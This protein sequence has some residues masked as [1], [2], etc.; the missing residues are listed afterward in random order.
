MK[1]LLLLLTLTVCRSASILA[2]DGSFPE[3]V[4]VT[5]IWDQPPHS[6]FTD[7]VLFNNAFYC[8]FREGFSHVDTTNSGKVRVLKSKDGKDWT[9]VA[10]LAIP[11]ID[12]RD[13]KLTI[14]PDKKLMVTMAGA[15]FAS[16]NNKNKVQRIAPMVSFSDLKGANFSEPQKS[17]LDPAI[18]PSL[19]WI[20]RTTWH[21]GT[22]YAIDY[23]VLTDDKWVIY[24]LKT[25]D[26]IKY[27][28]VSDLEVNGKP[29]E[30]TIRFDKTGKMYVLIRRESEDQMGIMAE[31]PAPYTNWTYHKM[32]IRLGGPNFLFLN[33]NK[34]VIG[35]RNYASPNKMALY[36]SDQNGNITKTIPFPSSGDASY[37]GMVI[38]Q[39]KLW[40]SYYSTHDGKSAIYLAQVPLDKLQ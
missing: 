23:Q 24:L 26:G 2:Q 14:T 6:A 11:K 35:S 17:T 15:V 40:V 38:H 32:S 8:T 30:S 29:N 27:D 21:N 31:S 20:W 7:L 22:G 33:D 12:L 18:S 13:P 19:D 1:K 39:N 3:Y 4:K 10:L 5:K 34:L 36:L 37:P 28:K 16:V 9:S 25:K